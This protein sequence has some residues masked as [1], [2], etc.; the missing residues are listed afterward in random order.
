MTIRSGEKHTRLASPWRLLALTCVLGY[1]AA[2]TAADGSVFVVDSTADVVDDNPG[3]GFCLTSGGECTLRAAV[4]EA[5]AWDGPDII[6]LSL[7]NDPNSPITLTRSGVDE[8]FTLT[9]GGAE[10]CIVD[11]EANAAI[12]DLDIT[13]DLQIVGAGPGLTVIQW[14]QQS[15]EDPDIGDRIFHVQ[16]PTGTTINLVRIADLM[17]TRGSVGILNDTTA[18]NPYNCEEPRGEAGALEVWQFRRFGGAVAV[19]PGAAVVL[20]QEQTHGPGT[21]GGGGGGGGGPPPGVGPGGDEGEETGGVTAVEF[22]RVAVI[23]NQSGS[24]AGGLIAAAE[25]TIRESVLSGNTSGGNGGALYLDSATSIYDTL[26]GSSTS[27]VPYAIGPVPAALLANPNQAENGGGIFD[28]GSHT[29][30]IERSALNGNEAIGG[31][32]IA[33]RSLVVINLTNST[34]SGNTGSDVGGGITTNG[35]VNLRNVT[36]ANNLA[37]TDAQG[38]GAGLNAFG[39]GTFTFFNTILSN[40]IVQ[41]GEAGREANCGCSGGAPQCAPG[42]MVSTGYNIS[43]EAENTCS[44]NVALNDQLATDPLIDALANNGGLTETHA[45]Q[46]IETGDL[47]TS[48]AVDAGDQARCPNNDQRG[49]LRPDDGDLNG[50]FICDIGAFE[51]FIPRSDLHINNVMAPNSVNKGDTFDV[52]VE[53]HNDDGNAAAPDVTLYVTLDTLT[54]ASI[55]GAVPTA[56]VCNIA[57]TDVLNCELGAMAI[58]DIQSV[59]LSLTANLQGSYALESVIGQSGDPDLVDTNPGNN[60]VTST[61]AVIG[62]SDLAV[63]G[64]PAAGPARIG[65]DITLDYTVVNNGEDEASE[66]RFGMVLPLGVDFVSATASVGDCALSAGEVRCDIGALT[67]AAPVAVQLAV[68]ALESGDKVFEALVAADQNDPDASNNAVSATVTVL[69]NADLELVPLN[70]SVQVKKTYAVR[71]VVRNQGPEAATNVVVTSTLPS[72]VKFVSSDDCTAA[73]NQIT[74]ALGDIAANAETTAILNVLADQTGSA[75][76]AGTVSADSNDPDLSNNSVSA[77]LTSY[78]PPSGGGGGGCVYLPGSG[79]DPTLPALLLLALAG[80]TWRRRA[81]V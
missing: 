3:D 38:G 43:D 31:G 53:V 29:T 68:T 77:K 9:P 59:T 10:A 58:G 22:D 71:F 61:F 56:G 44:L 69:R 1:G 18:D 73:G 57:S 20:F 15:I 62:N 13:Q 21:G 42:R 32:G 4:M 52:T 54:G 60:T 35:K 72:L 64:G 46:S 14:D 66:A 70:W 45:L 79:S 76:V 5:N 17:L 51:L 11:I 48:P 63:T 19:G 75:N 49:S 30:N 55:V 41:G 23:G 47:A 39:N 67:V 36:V 2:A 7:I 26:I 40:N 50:S 33:G 24:D 25:M 16:A 12:G 37:T 78:A 34:V 80:L 6:D 28:T 27:D 81:R 8:T 65:D 74:C